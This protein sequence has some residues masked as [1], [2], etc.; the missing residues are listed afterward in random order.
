MFKKSR[1]S[2]TNQMFIG[3]YLPA[4]GSTII[5][6]IADMADALVVGNRMGTLGLAAIAFSIPVYMLYNV[7]M[8]SFGTGGSIIF[9]GKITAGNEKKAISLYQG[10]MTILIISGILIAVL[11]NVFIHGVLFILGAGAV[12][13]ELYN[14]IMTYLRIVLVA[15]PFFLYD[16]CIS[17]F[18]RNDDMEKEA[19][20]CSAI[21]CITDFG[22]NIILVLVFNLGVMGAGLAT[23]TGVLLTSV[24]QTVFIAKKKAHLRFLPY[25][26]DIKGA[27]LSFKTGFASCVSYIYTFVIILIGNNAIIRLAG[28]EGVAVFDVVM[29]ISNTTTNLLGVTN[30]ASQPIISTYESECN[31]AECDKVGKGANLLSII[32]G[33]I[34]T[35]LISVFASNICRLFGI[36]SPSVVQYGTF[37]LRIYSLSAVF[38]G[39]SLSIANYFSARNVLFPTFLINTLRGIAVSLPV[40]FVFMSFGK[41]AI[42]F[43]FPVT[44]IIC[45]VASLLLLRIY[46]NRNNNR[47]DSERVF[48]RDIG[49]DIEAISPVTEL[50]KAFCKKWGGNMKQIYF[51]Q[52][53][54]EEVCSAIMT[55]GFSKHN[56]IDG[57]IQLTVVAMEDGMFVLHIR[58]NAVT[59]NPF[60][61]KKKSLAEMG[62]GDSEFNALGMDV[63]KQKAESFY[64]RRYQGFNTMVVKI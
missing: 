16:Y 55:N 11:G 4:L 63:I 59:F 1:H 22:L 50:I 49:H 9:A 62:N 32:I 58:D 54:I 17:F 21:G 45:F 56:H 38:V 20:I 39:V 15:A 24:V 5:F 52:M 23:F 42:W 26:P 57:K 19:S 30:L 44:E 41:N 53:T 7:I 28:E 48:T 10:V 47:I 29:N 14:S 31:Y 8:L 3:Q 27:L 35:V 64:Y 36:N 51:V 13:K 40:M 43:Y 60:G 37:A 2:F 33:L 6:A 18:M 25:N 34:L 46:S 12:E 61:M